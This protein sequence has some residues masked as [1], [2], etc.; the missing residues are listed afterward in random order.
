MRLFAALYDKAMI[1]ARHRYAPRWL[2]LVS[3]T[4]S[5]FFVIPPDIMLAPMALAQPSRAWRYAALTTLASVGGGL[6]GYGIGVLAFNFVEPLLHQWGYWDSYL[7]VRLWF[8][9][10][11]GWAVL[12]AGFSPVPYKLFT[13]AAGVVAMPLIPF[14]LA[15][16][17]GRGSRFFLVAMLMRFGGARMEGL[18][19]K[20]VDVMGWIV[21]AIGIGIYWLRYA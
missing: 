11:G 13:I 17:V 2:A 18:L 9:E 15:S 16:L 3:F 5:A 8:E 21:V 7:K 10:W 1:W 12:L 6:L 4:E 19:R 14:T 20:Y